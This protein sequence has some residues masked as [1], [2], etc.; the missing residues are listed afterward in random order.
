[1][2]TLKPPRAGPRRFA[3][4]TRTPRIASRAWSFARWP[5]ACPSMG[6]ASN[7]G[8][9][10]GTSHASMPLRPAAASAVP[11]TIATPATPPFVIQCFSPSSTTSSPSSRTVVATA[12]ASLPAPGSV[13]AKQ[14]IVAPESSRGSHV[15]RCASVP[16]CATVCVTRPTW[17]ARKP[18]TLPS[19]RPI[20][21]AMTAAASALAPPPPWAGS[22]GA[23]RSP[24]AAIRGTSARGNRPARSASRERGATSSSA[25]AWALRR[26]ASSAAERP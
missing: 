15:R 9:A 18:R 23:P 25:N 13:S 7:P 17:T 21:S 14:P 1:M 10:V 12:A 2:A 22:T 8:V 4:G 26:H 6:C 5:S 19:T 24:S 16:N 11:N 3:F 20:S